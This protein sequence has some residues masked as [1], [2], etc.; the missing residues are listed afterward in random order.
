MAL[1]IANTQYPK[2]EPMLIP[3]QKWGKIWIV[4]TVQ[5]ETE[6]KYNAIP[7]YP[8]KKKFGYFLPN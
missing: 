6:K 1:T 3:E 2:E 7:R 4:A 5:N 8:G